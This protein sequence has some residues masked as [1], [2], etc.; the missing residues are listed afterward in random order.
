MQRRKNAKQK[1]ERRNKELLP[2]RL[3]SNRGEQNN[4]NKTIEFLEHCF[5]YCLAYDYRSSKFLF[6]LLI[7]F[8][9]QKYVFKIQIFIHS[10]LLRI[11]RFAV[12]TSKSSI[13]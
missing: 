2:E 13:T 5:A 1:R 6:S 4:E 12:R 8:E 11:R 3:I 9:M 7:G 10:S